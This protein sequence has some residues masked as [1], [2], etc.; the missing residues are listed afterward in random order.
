MTNFFMK[1][2]FDKYFASSVKSI[3]FL[4]MTKV[5]RHSAFEYGKWRNKMLVS[6]AWRPQ[7]IRYNFFNF[8]GTKEGIILAKTKRF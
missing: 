6:I 7:S 1:Q 2:D 4:I 8:Y 5:D 3:P